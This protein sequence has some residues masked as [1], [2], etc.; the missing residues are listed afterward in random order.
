[1]GKFELF[2]LHSV[3]QAGIVVSGVQNPIP[4]K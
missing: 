3:T 2:V 4:N 1:M